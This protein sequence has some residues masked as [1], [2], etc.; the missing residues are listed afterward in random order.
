MPLKTKHSSFNHLE[1]IACVDVCINEHRDILKVI[2]PSNHE[3]NLKEA[4]EIVAHLYLLL[5]EYNIIYLI[6]DNSADFHHVSPEARIY[7]ADNPCLEIIKGHAVISKSFSSK[8]LLNFFIMFNKPI[9]PF[10]G[11]NSEEKAI[12]WLY[13]IDV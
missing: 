4:T 12:E 3:V 1:K 10:K 7:L 9:I 13:S 8:F 6:T 2:Y 5:K 11:F